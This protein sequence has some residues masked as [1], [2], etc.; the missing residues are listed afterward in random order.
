MVYLGS[1]KKKMC[2]GRE[3]AI[4]I[5]YIVTKRHTQPRY[6]ER[7]EGTA[8]ETGFYPRLATSQRY[9]DEITGLSWPRLNV[10]YTPRCFLKPRFRVYSTNLPPPALICFLA[11]SFM[12]MAPGAF[13]T[14][15]L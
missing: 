15:T 14:Q 4:T 3:S 6:H 7:A 12:R 13:V 2:G 8:R 11:A 9:C 10:R 1:D 5:R